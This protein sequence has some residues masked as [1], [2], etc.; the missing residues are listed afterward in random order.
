MKFKQWIVVGFIVIG[1]V[2][3]G[4]AT[5]GSDS[6][7]Q[8][9][10]VDKRVAVGAKG[11]LVSLDDEPLNG[12]EAWI[13]AHG[14]QSEHQDEH[15]ISIALAKA[16]FAGCIVNFPI[17]Y[18]E[19]RK[20]EKLED[21]VKGHVFTYDSTRDVLDIGRD[22]HVLVEGNSELTKANVP[23][24]IL[25]HSKSGNVVQA[26][27]LSSN[28]RKLV[29]VVTLDSPHRGTLIA[30]P[31]MLREAFVKLYPTVGEGLANLAES[32]VD[33]DSLGMKWLRPNNRMLL[34]LHNESPLDEKWILYGGTVESR[35]G[36]VWTLVELADAL[37]LKGDSADVS[38]RWSPAGAALIE[39]GGDISGSDG[40][41][42]LNSAWAVGLTNGAQTRLMV[43]YNHHEILH[44]KGGE[45][46][47]YRQILWDLVTF[48]PLS[49][50]EPTFGDMDFQLPSLELF[51]L[52]ESKRI[53]FS[54]SNRVWITGGQ[55]SVSADEVEGNNI[56]P[57]S[58][59][60]D[61]GMG[62]FSWPMWCQGNILTTWVLNGVS[63]IV[64]IRVNGEVS[65]LTTDG[66]SELASSN[67][68]GSLTV[69]ISG[70][71]LLV[72]SCDGL[73]RIVISEQLNISTPPV[74]WGNKI[75]FAHQNS[76][77]VYNLYWVNKDAQH[78]ALDDAKLIAQ[79]TCHPVKIQ[80]PWGDILVAIRIVG[81]NVELTAVLDNRLGAGRQTF[82]GLIENLDSYLQELNLSVQA[83]VAMDSQTGYLYIEH[84]GEIRQFDA[85]KLMSKFGVWVQEISDGGGATVYR[86]D[87]DEIL[88][89]IAVGVQLDVK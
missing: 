45:L 15:G 83:Q 77:G 38:A 66:Q 10:I 25:A 8:N 81:D 51:E 69:Y 56:N 18:E 64:L 32:R 84:N 72:R 55:I 6:I 58:S 3:T 48:P 89:I 16:L 37:L 12:R 19:V 27:Q 21:R 42:S 30:D 34:D 61:I 36:S 41:V 49:N 79:S 76:V 46:D 39:A 5:V 26:Y 31:S 59:H 57:G 28:G 52:S 1:A 70:G 73:T 86:S 22:F 35:K 17:L 24:V 62:E 78:Y 13:Y 44:G 71:R 47:L 74:V 7:Y 82:N 68:D 50:P 2:A 14:L 9:A 67:D 43:D 23:I 4:W 11:R 54:K 75:Y 20:G 80:S 63:D 40:L 29:R 85:S 65:Q 53:D 88:P 33:F 60:L 87:I